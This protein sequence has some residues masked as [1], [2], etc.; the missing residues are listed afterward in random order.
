[1]RPS[2][3]SSRRTIIAVARCN[4]LP[5]PRSPWRETRSRMNYSLLR[6]SAVRPIQMYS[7]TTTATHNSQP[8]GRLLP[9]DDVGTERIFCTLQLCWI[10]WKSVPPLLV[11]SICTLASNC[12][13]HFLCMGV[14]MFSS[15]LAGHSLWF[16]TESS[17]KPVPRTKRAKVW[18]NVSRR[19]VRSRYTDLHRGRTMRVLALVW[20]G[21]WVFCSLCLVT[22]AGGWVSHALRAAHRWIEIND[23]LVCLYVASGLGIIHA[24]WD[25]NWW[26]I[27]DVKIARAHVEV[28]RFSGENHQRRWQCCPGIFLEYDNLLGMAIVVQTL[29]CQWLCQWHQHKATIYVYAALCVIRVSTGFGIQFGTCSTNSTNINGQRN[30]STYCSLLSVLSTSVLSSTQKSTGIRC[31]N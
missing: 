26:K 16:R 11:L 24:G 22:G 13:V 28:M 19:R 30:K 14:C 9:A 29:S 27:V 31:T 10:P 21:N 15:M 3:A 5:E 25:K 7:T 2:S 4:R 12:A 23:M 1:M 18:R 8:N 6:S 17:A 20:C